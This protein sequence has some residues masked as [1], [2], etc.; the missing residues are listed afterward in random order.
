MVGTHIHSLFPGVEGK[1][2]SSFIPPCAPESSC[3]PPLHVEKL[4][5][6]SPLTD[7]T[8]PLCAGSSWAPPLSLGSASTPPIHP[9]TRLGTHVVPGPPER[10]RASLDAAEGLPGVA[11]VPEL[12]G[13]IVATGGELLGAVVAPVQVVDPG[14]VGRDVA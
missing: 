1:D 4:M 8:P 10:L 14:H 12:D 6:S 9:G 13:G 11:D 2:E 7:C 5:H 3:A